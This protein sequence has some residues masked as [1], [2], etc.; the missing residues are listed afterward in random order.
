MTGGGRLIRRKQQHVSLVDDVEATRQAC[1]LRVVRVRVHVGM[2]DAGEPSIRALQLAHQ[3]VI[4]DLRRSGASKHEQGMAL[5][6]AE[7][8][9]RA[10]QPGRWH[11]AEH[12]C[13]G[14]VSQRDACEG[15]GKNRCR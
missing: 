5:T 8:S 12:L 13:G 1:T 9:D 2:Q 4:R 6:V 14:P 11:D 7:S 15:T 3:E 10:C